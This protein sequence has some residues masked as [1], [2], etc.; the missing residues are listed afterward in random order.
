L[1]ASRHDSHLVVESKAD[2]HVYRLLFLDG[3]LLDVV[4]RHPPR[5]TGDGVSTIRALI[6]AENRRRL[7]AEGEAGLPLITANLDM[8]LTLEH[9]RMSLS[10]VPARDDRVAV[11]TV[12]NQGGPGDNETVREPVSPDLVEDARRAAA[13]VGV[14]LAGVD[15]ITPAL[16]RSLREAGGVVIEVNGGP[17]L[18]H[19]YHVRDRAAATPVCVPVLEH[20]LSSPVPARG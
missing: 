16:D 2:G 19:H 11:K 1:L 14:R 3:E 20:L 15:L 12:T 13:A 4:R 9:D 8:L 6:R 5:V 17:G 7:E 10:T 18:H